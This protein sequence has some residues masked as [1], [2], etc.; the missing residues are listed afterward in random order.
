MS[1]YGVLARIKIDKK[2]RCTAWC[3]LEKID[4]QKLSLLNLSK[5][6]SII[7]TTFFKNIITKTF[8]NQLVVVCLFTKSSITRI[9]YSFITC[10]LL[11]ITS[12]S[13]WGL[14]KPC[15][16]WNITLFPNWY[17]YFDLFSTLLISQAT[18]K[19]RRPW[20]S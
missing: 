3:F 16:S 2:L 11:K 1:L 15:F 14:I 4:P 6:D 7:S 9:T 19:V 20:L 12:W 8:E 17:F 18:K 5:R 13:N 10:F